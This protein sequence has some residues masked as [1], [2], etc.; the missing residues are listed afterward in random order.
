MKKVLLFCAAA[1]ALLLSASC[2]KGGDT[3]EVV[4]PAAKYAE[5]A[6]KLNLLNSDS[7]PGI[8]SIEF[9]ESGR[10]IICHQVLEKAPLAVKAVANPTVK[11]FHGTYT[12][13]NNVYTLSGEFASTVTVIGGQI[14]IQTSED[15]IVLNYEEA[16]KYPANEFYTTV[17]RAWKVDKTDISVNFDGKSAVGVVKTGCDIPAILKELEQKANVDLKDE[18][19]AGYVVSEINFTMSKTMEVAFTGKDPIAGPI[20]FS[21]NGAVS[22][23]LNGSNGVEI[24]SG[25]ATGTFNLNP[26]LGSNQIM[27]TLNTE[28]TT[29]SGKTYNGNVSFIL[30]PAE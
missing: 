11:Y 19:F 17:A 29:K 28:I 3:K 14:T 15:T 12:V 20:S 22:Y 21:E 8:K 24:L 9:T 27:L 6:K 7:N 2:N 1:V 26:G 18:E 13:N 25:S 16:E 30:S 5:Q 4:L 23:E 10:Y